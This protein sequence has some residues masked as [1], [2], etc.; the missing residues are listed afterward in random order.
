MRLQQ[1]GLQMNG[2][3]ME[4]I[5][6]VKLRK[7]MT[8]PASLEEECGQGNNTSE[9]KMSKERFFPGTENHVPREAG[10]GREGDE[11]ERNRA[12]RVVSL[13]LTREQMRNLQS[14]PSLASALS[15]ET[16]RECNVIQRK[17]NSVVIR[18]QFDSVPPLRLLK[19]EEVL[20]MLR[21][22]KSYLNK[23]VK[24]GNVKSYKFGR[25]RRFMLD[26]ILSYL[27]DHQEIPEVRQ[28]D[29]QSR[30]GCKETV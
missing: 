17:E 4:K 24:A 7:K 3:I 26:D 19:S 18:F 11:S 2:G 13:M 20:H 30:I 29:S 9:D 21:I 23:A 1:K 27:A 10:E 28:E 25:L 5:C 16:S 15:G 22:S 6:I 8:T 14:N 12:E